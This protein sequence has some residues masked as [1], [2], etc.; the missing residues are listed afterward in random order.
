MVNEF[1]FGIGLHDARSRAKVQ[2]AARLAEDL[3]FDVLHVPDHLGAPAPFP[4]LMSAAA[5]TSTLRLGTFVL[6]AGFY[7][8]AL[9]ARD[10]GAMRDLTEGRFEL[11]L[12]TGYVRK[13]F[14]AAELP[15]P[16]ARQ[17]IDHMEHVIEYMHEHLPD[18]PI[19]IAGNGDR[20]LTI[21]AQQ[22]DIIGFTGGDRAASESEDPL[23]ERIGFVRNAAPD[24]FDSLELNVAITAMPID[25]SGMPD[26]T[27]PRR[28]LP[29]LTDEE[30]LRHPGVL[31][32]STQD[33]ADRIRGY[34][35]TYGISYIIVQA[36]HAEV[37][38]KVMAELR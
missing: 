7:K 25:E 12:G 37:F 17:R 27:I 16:S 34:R 15:Y 14:E 5:A 19:L 3:G 38:A 8:P 36:P 9:L 10:V 24:R 26:L 31:S 20:V 4:A 35:D 21:S 30:L 33:M 23:A 28:F 22:A 32:G 1:R 29:H 18:V 2:D 11:G 13:E 6:N